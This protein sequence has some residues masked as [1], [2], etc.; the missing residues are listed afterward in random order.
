MTLQLRCPF[1]HPP[2]SITKLIVD[3]N[4]GAK[5]DESRKINLHLLA[6][7][8]EVG[9]RVTG[10]NPT[11]GVTEDMFDS[12]ATERRVKVRYA[13]AS[14]IQRALGQ[15]QLYE[16]LSGQVVSEDHGATGGAPRTYRPGPLGARH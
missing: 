4:A 15:L 2:R 3:P 16:H 14:D 7:L 11:V 8:V 10:C 13:S 5:V 1:E 12:V 9:D 6:R